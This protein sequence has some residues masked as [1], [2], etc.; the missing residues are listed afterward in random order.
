M[1]SIYDPESGHF[2]SERH[3]HVA[4]ILH[5]YNPELELR[6]IPP[7]RRSDPQ[8]REFPFAVWH[9]PKDKPA[10]LVFLVKEDEVDQRLLERVFLADQAKN[11][12]RAR[13][14]AQNAAAEAMRLFDKAAQ[15]EEMAEFHSWLLKTPRSTVRHNGKVYT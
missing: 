12:V 13:L 4:T 2:V 3:Q 14:M 10:Y 8:D 5:D 15:E 9:A 7:E 1:R 11:D 6:W